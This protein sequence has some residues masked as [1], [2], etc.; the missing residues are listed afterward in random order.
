MF[1]G[2]RKNAR[3]YSYLIPPVVTSLGMILIMIIK[4][5][6]PFGQM[7]FGYNDNM[8]QVV[9][10]YSLIWDVLHG[11]AS[12]VYSLQMG[13]GTDLSAMKSVFSMS[14]PFNLLL[15]L[16]PRSHILGFI[17]VMTIIKMACMSVAMYFFLNHDKRFSGTPYSFKALFSI[18]YS[19]SGYVLLY[20]SCFSPWMDVAA[21]FPL[22]M[23]AYNKM[24]EGGGRLF[25]IIMTAVMLIMNSGL[26]MMALLYAGIITGIYAIVVIGMRR[27]L[28]LNEKAYA[29]GRLVG[30]ITVSTLAGAGLAAFAVLPC[31]I[32]MW[33]GSQ[34]AGRS[35]WT[36]YYETIT[37]ELYV[38]QLGIFQHFMILYGMSFAFAMII[39]GVIKYKKEVRITRYMLISLLI[40]LIP[41]IIDKTERIWN[42][43]EYSGYSVHF[44]FITAFAVISTGAYFAGKP[45]NIE[46]TGKKNTEYNVET[47]FEPLERLVY[48][49]AGMVQCAI[50]AYIYNKLELNETFHALLYFVFVF[51]VMLVFNIAVCLIN[52]RVFCAKCCYVTVAIEIFAGA[53][54][55]IGTPRFYDFSSEQSANY[56]IQAVSAANGLDV[57]SSS[58]DGI[59]SP[60]MSLGTNYSTVFQRPTVSSDFD[61]YCRNGMAEKLGYG[62]YNKTN[63]D[64]GGTV[65]S[66]A[67]LHITQIVSRADEDTALYKNLNEYD[68]FRLYDSIYTL[69]YAMTVVPDIEGY[70]IS[71]SYDSWIDSN[72]V[73]YRAITGR[74]EDIVSEAHITESDSG[75]YTVSID[76]RKALY[77]RL[78]TD[79]PVNV[80][81]N[82]N[83]TAVPKAGALNNTLYGPDDSPRLLYLGIFENEEVAIAVN[84]MA[85]NDAIPDIAGIDAGVLDM[86]RLSVVCNMMKSNTGLSASSYRV[87]HGNEIKIIVNAQDGRSMLLLPVR[88]DD[89]WDAETNGNSTSIVP[90]AGGMMMGVML[91]NGNN[92]VEMTFTPAGTQTGMA[93]SVFTFLILVAA[94]SFASQ[95]EISISH[96]LSRTFAVVFIIMWVLF[97]I[98]MFVVPFVATVVKL[99]AEV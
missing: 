29:A 67:V 5:I 47:V 56:A 20:A 30:G 84:D 31:A 10:M 95:R 53:Y 68:G 39:I 19:F 12:S 49:L 42:L 38:S 98:A 9:P 94:C 15:Y 77:I 44:G 43:K 14:S 74:D 41:L 76:G 2:N 32:K 24:Q 28:R 72:N 27:D 54:A 91:E 97:V 62:V 69:P 40:T 83:V 65:F 13:M 26:G 36:K 60:D 45:L 87:K 51:T 70:E 96:E 25:Y 58:T 16:V 48:L 75:S 61:S 33:E 92:T 17:P 23:L 73:I 86:G 6:Y 89:N 57:S 66:D 64:V 90:V 85:G 93:V 22:F 46:K 99:I 82:G 71:H 7:G 8:H 11:R 50:W 37:S 52:K 80:S 78:D 81:A 18:M 79:I 1:N 35:I 63:A 34:A 3:I 4:Q 21:V 59:R 88:Y 55:M